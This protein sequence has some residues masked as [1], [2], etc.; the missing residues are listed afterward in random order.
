MRFRSSFDGDAARRRSEQITARCADLTRPLGRLGMHLVRK[1]NRILR[2]GERGV[3]ARTAAGLAASLTHAVTTPTQMHV[4]S[5]K[6]YAR[7]HQQGGVIQPVNAQYLTIPIADNIGARQQ[8]R[9]DSPREVS[10][11]FFIRSKTTGALLFVRHLEKKVDRRRDRLRG[12]GAQMLSRFRSFSRGF[13][14]LFLLV[15]HVTLPGRQYCTFDPP[16]KPVWER[17]AADWVLRGK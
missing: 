2:S 3:Q 11:G 6:A 16:D 1:T 17:Y 4:G 8:P 9:Y 5:N 10:D 13:E 15:K 14:L 7:I 12:R